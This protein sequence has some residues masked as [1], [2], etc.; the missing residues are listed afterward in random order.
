MQDTGSDLKVLRCTRY[1]TRKHDDKMYYSTTR[2]TMTQKLDHIHS[3]TQRTKTRQDLLQGSGLD[4]LIILGILITLPLGIRLDG[5]HK[6]TDGH[7]AMA[8]PRAKAKVSANS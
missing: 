8:C 7:D 3:T 1:V 4:I 2:H 5:L 6:I